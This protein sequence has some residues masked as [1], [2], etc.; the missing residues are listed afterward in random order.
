MKSYIA[1][2]V[3]MILWSVFYIAEW[4]SDKDH[5]EYKWIMFV[6]F[7]YL[8]FIAA[9]KIVQSRKLTLFIT[10]F[11]LTCFFAFKVVFENVM[12]IF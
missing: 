9:K 5:L 10:S 3:Q 1:F 7:F 11:S 2:L 6:I 8:A 4:M 12:E